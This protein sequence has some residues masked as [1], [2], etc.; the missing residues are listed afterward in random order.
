MSNLNCF[1][2]PIDITEVACVTDCWIFNRL[3]IIKTSPNYNDWIAS[4][5]NIFA[6]SGYNFH[7]G[8]LSLTD[9][10][11]HDDIL[12]RK[13]LNIFKIDQTNVVKELSHKVAEGYYIN[14]F[15]KQNKKIDK[16]HEVI[17]YGFDNET[18]SFLV[19]GHENRSFKKL[20]ITY[21]LLTETWPAIKNHF[22][23]NSFRGMELSLNYQYPATLFKLKEN[24]NIE[25]CAVEAYKKICKE[26]QGSK[27][28]VFSS[29]EFLN[30]IEP[31][32]QYQGIECLSAAHSM[33]NDMLNGKEFNSWFRG[34]TSA[35]KKLYEHRKMILLSMKYV[36][37][38]WQI[39]MNEK[40]LL[41]INEYEN[42]LKTI[43]KWL[44]LS[45][46]Y[47]LTKNRKDLETI[48]NDLPMIYTNEKTILNNFIHHTI[49]W[50]IF[51]ENF[52]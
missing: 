50:E 42:N 34:I 40:S 37:K 7:F 35:I 44:N 47:E 27:V 20:N 14:I 49:D 38:K 4:R 51:N 26:L 11:Y 39:C 12:E 3:I 2:L 36:Y 23:F 10:N 48:L 6:T 5:Y 21:S 46:H 22:I 52:I 8:D 32:V 41:Y 33:I 15:I 19:V 45:L 30:Y 43:E 31:G 13:Q 25:N 1:E 16:Y 29:Q 18:N 17:I 9:P 28:D 24:F